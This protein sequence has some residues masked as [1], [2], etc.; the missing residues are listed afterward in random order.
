[1]PSIFYEIFNKNIKIS[2]QILKQLKEE[3][4]V[5]FEKFKEKNDID[6]IKV[7]RNKLSHLLEE[8]HKKID[9]K[10]EKEL[11]NLSKFL[12]EI[13]EYIKEQEEEGKLEMIDVVE[14]IEKKYKKCDN[15][16]EEKRKKYRQVCKKKETI[17][18]EKE[19]IKLQVELLKLQKHVKNT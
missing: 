11:K 3:L 13:D 9:K 5:L 8:K 2:R 12:E 10:T 7:L 19:L 18:Y 14:K 17:A 4:E 6:Y 15:L 1:M 16:S